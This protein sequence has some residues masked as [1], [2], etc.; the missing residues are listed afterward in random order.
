MTS[1]VALPVVAPRACPLLCCLRAP[2]PVRCRLHPQVAK[3]LLPRP[4]PGGSP[5]P[6]LPAQDRSG[7]VE[8]LSAVSVWQAIGSSPT[9][10]QRPVCS[11]RPACSA[12]KP[13]LLVREASRRALTTSIP[14]PH[15]QLVSA[16]SAVLG[17]PRLGSPHCRDLPGRG[18]APLRTSATPPLR[19]R[20]PSP[21]PCSA[22]Y[23]AYCQELLVVRSVLQCPG[24]PLIEGRAPGTHGGNLKD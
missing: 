12:A 10:P 21:Q 6:D 16:V 24:D 13:S 9:R 14:R 15:G 19:P 3:P 23:P 17:R 5:T 8:L 20:P 4:A 2:S 11:P 18:A 22:R 7:P 1:G